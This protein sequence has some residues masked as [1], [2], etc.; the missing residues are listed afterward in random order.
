MPMNPWRDFNVAHYLLL[1][2][3]LHRQKCERCIWV[4]WRFFHS[5]NSFKI[6][7]DTFSCAYF[8]R[9]PYYILSKILY[10]VIKPCITSLILLKTM[11]RISSFYLFYRL[12]E[13]VQNF[14]C[15]P[16]KKE[17]LVSIRMA[18]AR[19]VS[20]IQILKN[21]TL[22]DSNF[23]TIIKLYIYS[24]LNLKLNAF[25]IRKRNCGGFQMKMH[26]STFCERLLG[27]G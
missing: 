24:L 15:S 9:M 23:R 7:K 27:F 21:L 11:Y 2:V 13:R 26:L 22:H 10:R 8:M 25:E 1:L 14:Y 16:E 19:S 18:I 3:A 5:R 17:K 20:R 6:W 12:F 4:I